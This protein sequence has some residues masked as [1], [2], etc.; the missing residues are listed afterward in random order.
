MRANCR[1]LEGLV[2][3]SLALPAAGGG[4]FPPALSLLV[5]SAFAFPKEVELILHLANLLT[6]GLLVGT[7][8]WMSLVLALA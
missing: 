6:F 8:K 5:F 7:L 4:P 2:R 1:A 3:G